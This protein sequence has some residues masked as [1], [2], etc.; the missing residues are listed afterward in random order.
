MR[1]TRRGRIKFGKIIVAD[2]VFVTMK[3]FN[4]CRSGFLNPDR[5]LTSDCR[6]RS[7]RGNTKKFRKYRT[8]ER[9]RRRPS[10]TRTMALFYRLRS[11]TASYVH[12]HRERNLVVFHADHDQFLHCQSG[13]LPHGGED[14]LTHPKRRGSLQTEGNQIR[15]GHQWIYFHFLQGSSQ[16]MV[17]KNQKLKNQKLKTKKL[18]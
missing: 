17:L 12:S 13:R 10:L 11:C 3:E 18:K 6:W 4:R 1:T 14:D 16:I 15:N 8:S 2:L 5:F 9:K 7:I